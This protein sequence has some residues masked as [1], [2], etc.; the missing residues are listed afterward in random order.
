MATRLLQ[1]PRHRANAPGEKKRKKRLNIHC[2]QIIEPEG[3]PTGARFLGH[4]GYYVQ[5]PLNTRNID[6]EQSVRLF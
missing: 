1:P 2:T 3:V 4:Q 6:R 5:E